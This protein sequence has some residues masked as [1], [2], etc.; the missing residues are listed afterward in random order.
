[1]FRRMI[2]RSFTVHRGL[3]FIRPIIIQATCLGRGWHLAQES[4]WA[5]RGQT[6]GATAIGGTA[7]SPL[8]TTTILIETTST[9]SIVASR[10]E[11]GSTMLNIAAVLLTETET[12][13][14]NTA[15]GANRVGGAAGGGRGTRFAGGTGNQGG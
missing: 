14:T 15:G 13:L 6:I 3:I 1:M 11:N 5:Q 10:A 2:R 8:T 7:T 4:Y 12:R 9:I